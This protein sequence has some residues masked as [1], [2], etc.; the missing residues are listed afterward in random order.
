MTLRRTRHVTAQ[1]LCVSLPLSLVVVI[2]MK[3]VVPHK[4]GS[5]IGRMLR[6]LGMN[7]GVEQSPSYQEIAYVPTPTESYHGHPKELKAALLEAERRR[8][9]ALME[10]QRRPLIC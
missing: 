1:L 7:G 8:A 5:L 10:R 2:E 3:K 6:S 9:E 4:K